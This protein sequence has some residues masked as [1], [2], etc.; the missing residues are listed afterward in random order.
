MTTD[1]HSAT[2]ASLTAELD[3]LDHRL[4]TLLPPVYQDAYEQVQPVSM[5]SAGLKF[6]PDGRVA[7]NEIWGSFCDLAMAGGP[8]HRGTLLQAPTPEEV[9]AQ[10]EASAAVADEICRGLMLVTGLPARRSATPGWVTLICLSETMADWLVR[11]VTM[12]NVAARGAGAM[13]E[14]P[15]GPAFRLEKETK[16]VIT[17]VAKTCHYWMGHIP[18]AQR[19]AIASLF[20]TL[21]QTSPM[22]APAYPRA[23]TTIGT[24]DG[25]KAAYARAADGA[26]EA[27]SARTG[28]AAS[29]QRDGW[30]GIE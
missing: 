18:P 21:A 4:R 13:I 19:Q 12:E 15:A 9:A 6:G 17:S 5:G 10:P 2:Q 3:V 30:L 24:P 1:S 11:A 25:A 7:W 14:L 29:R 22:L 23:E 28:L 26:I 27:L 20:V 16:N 8:P